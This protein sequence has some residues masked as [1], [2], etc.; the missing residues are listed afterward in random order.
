M[1]VTF[2]WLKEY[3]DFEMNVEKFAEDLTMMGL[4]VENIVPVGIQPEN[5]NR[6]LFSKVLSV[7]K[8]PS[9]D[10]LTLC[11]VKNSVGTFR[12]VTNSS[13]V[14][15]GDHVVHALPD[16]KLSN[17]IFIKEMKLKGEVSEG[18]LLPLQYLGL[19]EKSEDIWILGSNEKIAKEMFE[20]WTQ[21][22]FVLHIELTSNRSDC[23]SVI[24]VAREAAAMMNKKLKLPEF[25]VEASSDEIPAITIQDR[26]LCPRYTSRILRGVRVGSSP[27]EIRRKLRLCG[28]RPI[29]NVVDAT[30]YVLLEYGH[31]THA[32]DLHRLSGEKIVVRR[33]TA[34]E[35]L[36]TLDG[37]DVKLD[38]DMLVIADAK[39][40][41]ALAGI[42]G[43]AN[44][45]ILDESEDI[46]LE[47]AYFDPVSIRRSSR[48]TGVRTESSYRFERNADW[49]IP[50]V[51]LDRIAD[52]L[53]RSSDFQISQINDQ[54]VNMRKD[55]VV[56]IKAAF[57]NERL[58]LKLKLK[59][60]E[61]LLKRLRFS[62]TV[63]R[64]ESLEVKIPTFRSD[65]SRPI[66]LVEEIARVYGYNNIS[67]NLFSP[68]VDLNSLSR[69][70]NVKDVIRPL[71]L[72]LGLTETYNYPF[73]NQSELKKNHCD[74][75]GVIAVENPLN[76]ESTHLRHYLFPG[77]LKIVEYNLSH[78]RLRS[79]KFYELGRTFQQQAGELFELEKLALILFGEGSDYAQGLG[80]VESLLKRLGADKVSFTIK[81]RDFLH[82]V[83]AVIVKA[84]G[85]EIGFFGEIHPAVI[86]NYDIHGPVFGAELFVD[87]LQLFHEKRFTP[88]A[89]SK[90]PSTSRDLS[91]VVDKK[92]LAKDIENHIASY[93][94]WIESVCVA[95][96]FEGPGIGENKKSL[97]FS[98][99][100]QNRE[101]TMTDEET[102]NLIQGLLDSLLKNFNA[103]IRG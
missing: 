19:E 51:A 64:E 32:F 76:K 34:G 8:H 48:R 22:D 60:I 45:E 30:N 56:T 57:V 35:V 16:T 28:I 69:P 59:E 11:K 96:L 12:I 65:I 1:I 31:P 95:D 41:V 72:A 54:Y 101:K 29:N 81:A 85:K 17:D 75:I 74:E 15:K 39:N 9:A 55:V 84:D 10:K 83:N 5:K 2:N 13:R 79:L 61:N 49:G 21:A 53:S 71:M 67:E 91:L 27:D 88:H 7:K 82:P 52:I 40:P 23:L 20:F 92:I 50:P 43:G 80:V 25:K 18:M 26:N 4:E 37:T 102:K 89:V 70:Q 78:T 63:K 97:T 93:H 46:L 103:E 66:D 3:L 77:L 42:M 24:G 68:S 90:F 87:A 44:S 36:Q 58:G 73:T 62:I 14:A 38:K 98:L 100:I 6:I 86:E 33:A 47:S 94:N 99:V